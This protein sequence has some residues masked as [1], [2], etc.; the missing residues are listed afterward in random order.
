VATGVISSLASPA[1]LRQIEVTR[2]H[3]VYLLQAET[4]LAA[5][6]ESIYGVLLDYEHFNR[7]SRIYKEHRYLDPLPDGTP[8]IYTRMEGCLLF[9]CKSMRRVERMQFEEAAYIRTDAL[10]EQSDF[11]SSYSEWTLEPEF[12]GT[13]MFYTLEMEPDFWVPPVIGPWLLQ[14][15]LEQGG[16]RAIDRIERLAQ[17]VDQGE[18]AG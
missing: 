14:R 16:G 11:K 12:D 3:G 10:P 9:Y 13:R 15:T 6:P 17:A 8:M 7:I 2:K 1:T 4:Y 18:H 5:T